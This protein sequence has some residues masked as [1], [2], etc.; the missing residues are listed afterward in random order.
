MI[1]SYSPE[2][3][4]YYLT[5]YNE[6]I[7]D[8]DKKVAELSELELKLFSKKIKE[9]RKTINKIERVLGRVR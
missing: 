7:T 5:T 4:S 9:M 8:T 6:S 2:V 1:I 3:N